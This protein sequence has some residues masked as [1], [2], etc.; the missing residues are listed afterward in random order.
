MADEFDK[1]N[2]LFGAQVKVVP[3]NTD[4]SFVVIHGATGIGKTTTLCQMP[5]TILIECGDESSDTLKTSGGLPSKLPVVTANGYHNAI[6]ILKK[7]IPNPGDKPLFKRVVVDGASGLNRWSDALTVSGRMDGDLTKFLDF[8]GVNGDKHASYLWSDLV[9]V[10]KELRS[11]GVW[12]FL[13]CHSMVVSIR[14]PDGSD[15][16]RTVPE[17]GVGKARLA[18]TVKE[19]DAVWFF[20]TVV[21]TINADKKTGRGGKAIGGSF[22]VIKTDKT[23]SYEA[24]DRL[25]LPG[26]I[27]LGGSPLEGARAIHAAIKSG[28]EKAL[29]LQQ[30]N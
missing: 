22:R 23:A 14:N 11:A 5:G 25:N 7:L 19:A 21:E 29:A 4:A 28:R 9:E 10:I 27:E 3:V 20:D 26:L 15:Y 12:V 17:I 13:I 30:S 18:M 2:A 6:D 1:L 16:V 8:G 24:K